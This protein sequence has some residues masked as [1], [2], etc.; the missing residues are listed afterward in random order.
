M[1]VTL[2]SLIHRDH[3]DLDRTLTAM[4]AP[5]TSATEAVALLEALRIGMTAHAIG[6]TMVFRDLL[7]LSCPQALTAMVRTILDEHRAQARALAALANARPGTSAWNTRAS[8]L[9]GLLL[10]HVAREELARISQWDHV[11]ADVQQSLASTYATERLRR[12]AVVD[13]PRREPLSPVWSFN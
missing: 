13:A 1:P 3:E 5:P 7:D 9:R 10:D 4:T 8:E 11:P 6:Q 12:M 2:A